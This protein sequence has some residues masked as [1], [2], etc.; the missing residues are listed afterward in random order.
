MGRKGGKR[1]GKKG[2]KGN[3]RRRKRGGEGGRGNKLEVSTL[4]QVKFQLSRISKFPVKSKISI[5]MCPCVRVFFALS[6]GEQWA[7]FTAPTPTLTPTPTPTP[8]PTRPQCIFLYHVIIWC[9]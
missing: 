2:E 4:K 9:F 7:S 5:K 1:G 8:T 6:V 3:E